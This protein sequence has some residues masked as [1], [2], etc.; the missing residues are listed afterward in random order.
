MFRKA[1][2][3]RHFEVG[4][5]YGIGAQ[6]SVVLNAVNAADEEQLAA[7]KSLILSNGIVNLLLVLVY[8][9]GIDDVLLSY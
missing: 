2:I 5:E 4:P 8:D 1:L 9:C 6:R 3:R 7:G